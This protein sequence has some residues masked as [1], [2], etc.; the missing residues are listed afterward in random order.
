MKVT[1][2]QIKALEP[3]Q[4]GWDWYCQKERTEDLHELL[5][6]INN[7]SPANARWLFT[8]L[9]TKMQ[10]V[11]IAIF[12]AREVLHIFEEK[13]PKDG[14]SR[15]AIE[16]AEKYLKE[17][18][19]K[20][21]LETY[22]TADYV[23]TT[24]SDAVAYAYSADYAAAAYAAAYAADASYSAA[25]AAAYAADAS[26]AAATDAAAYAAKKELQLKI[27][28]KAVEILDRDNTLTNTEGEEE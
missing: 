13:R 10:C 11:E 4:P 12:S 15:K 28:K 18:T 16:A 22:T 23:A 26:Y 3:C 7:D 27:I 1:K 17:P 25:Y 6:E 14:R 24:Y 19:E 8:N 21:R 2:K 20:N 9:M 5:I